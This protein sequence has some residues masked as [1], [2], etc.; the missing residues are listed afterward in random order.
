VAVMASI[1]TVSAADDS[2]ISMKISEG[3]SIA[4][5][6][7]HDAIRINANQK[8][9]YHSFS[10][11]LFGNNATVTKAT[12]NF[13][14]K[15]K[16]KKRVN[17][18]HTYKKAGWYTLKLQVTEIN[19]G[20][21]NV[22]GNY[23]KTYRVQVVKRPDLKINHNRFTSKSLYSRGNTVFLRISIKNQ[24]AKVAKANTLGLHNGNK[25]FNRI[26]TAK[27]PSIKAGKSVKVSI[28]L[29]K[30]MDIRA[31]VKANNFVLQ[32]KYRKNGIFLMADS[33]NRVSESVKSNN[34]LRVA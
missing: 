30:I 24:G 18:T 32:K 17:A 27:I 16:V 13:G 23:T 25:K 2:I 11:N 21:I 22:I 6:K 28:P 14:D 31:S 9:K 34:F 29:N 7:G 19:A 1:T 5:N 26:D 10:E 4:K 33:T 3:D 8:I 12:W 15:S 20:N